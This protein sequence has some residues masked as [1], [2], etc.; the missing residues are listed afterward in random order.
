MSFLKEI[1]KI[2]KETVKEKK[3][4]N[5]ISELKNKTTYKKLDFYNK[6]EDRNVNETKII[7]EIKK[8]SPLKGILRENFDH[9]KIAKIYIENSAT[10]ISVITEERFFLGSLTFLSDI[11]SSF[12]IPLLRKDFLVDEYEIYESKAYGADCILL[13]SEILEKSQIKDYLEIARELDLDVLLEIHSL[14]S[15]EKISDLTGYLLGINNRDLESLKI[16]PYN[17]FNIIR[18]IPNSSPIIIESGIDNRKIIVEYLNA[19]VS[20]FLIGTSLISSLDISKKLRELQG[21]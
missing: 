6:F 18:N 8:A 7:A 9:L 2:K 12:N 20:G 15:Y 11:K 1:V 16:D 4:K 14:K 19:G 21:R 10:A 13:I 17:A 5:P 3:S